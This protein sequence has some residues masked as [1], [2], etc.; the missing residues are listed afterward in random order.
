MT[1]WTSWIG[2]LVLVLVVAGCG[3]AS[4]R[5]SRPPEG[6]AG[7]HAPESFPT[8]AAIAA[9]P[10]PGPVQF[11][12]GVSVGHW[13]IEAASLT[14]ASG[15]VEALYGPLAEQRAT[16][17]RSVALECVARETARFAAEVNGLPSEPVRRFLSARCGAGTTSIAVGVL[18]GSAPAGASDADVVAH[19]TSTRIDEL[20][21]MVDPAANRV[22]TALVRQGQSV[23]VAVASALSQLEATPAVPIAS[24]GHLRFHVRVARSPDRLIVMSTAGERRVATC[25]VVGASPELDVDCPFAEG[26]TRAYVEILGRDGDAVLCMPLALV[27]GIAAEGAGLAY[28]LRAPTAAAPIAGA[29]F[30]AAILPLLNGEREQIGAPPLALSA[31]QSL[32][33]ARVAPYAFGADM[34]AVEQA[35]LYTMAGWDLAPGPLVREGRTMEIEAGEVSDAGQ[36]LFRALETPLERWVLLDPEARVI[37]LGAVESDGHTLG[38][39]TTYRYFEGD[40][41]S[42]RAAAEAAFVAARREAG[43]AAPE[44]VHHPA[45]ERAALAIAEQG[46]DPAAAMDAALEELVQTYA[47]ARGSAYVASV[48]E[49]AA[50]GADVLDAPRVGIAV[51][52]ARPDGSAWGVYVVVVVALP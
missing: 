47:S 24:E 31:E 17:Q 13:E 20:I 26:D 41:E 28:D 46:A 49:H 21:G 32:A 29:D 7:L 22:G 19:V 4:A 30:G 10:P 15:A 43:R 1:R 36:W 34:S 18:P 45:L 44:F 12:S 40:P 51:R 52:H 11:D 35:I 9:L 50:W 5:P 39:A 37:A 42:D 14:G 2:V 23:F 8:A 48:L 6:Q 38:L 33:N 3:G 27:A 25:S 16:A